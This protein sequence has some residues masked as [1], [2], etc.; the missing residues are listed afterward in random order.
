MGIKCLECNYVESGASGLHTYSACP[1]CGNTDRDKFIRVD[2][3]DIIPEKH[4][5]DKN[6]LE[7]RKINE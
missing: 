2:D 4:Q 7:S 6:Y 1:K 3:E 5:Q